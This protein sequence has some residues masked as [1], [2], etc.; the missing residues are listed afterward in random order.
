[1]ELDRRTFLKGVAAVGG[2]AA[3]TGLA[4][5]SPQEGESDPGGSSGSSGSTVEGGTIYTKYPNLDGIGILH[6]TEDEETYDFVIVG[7]GITGLTAA[8]ITAEQMGEA[9]V[10]I[11]DKMPVPGGS[12][13]FAEIQSGGQPTTPEAA[14]QRAFDTAKASSYMKNPD[15]L[16][17]LYLD[18]SK[19]GGWLFYKQGFRH[20]KTN[21]FYEGS[22]AAKWVK[23]L[24]DRI[25]SDSTYENIEIRVDTQV[26]ALLMEDSHTCVGVQAHGTSDVGP[27]TNIKAKAIL[28]ATGGCSTNL[29]LL[30]YYTGHDVTEKGIGIGFGQDGDGFLLVENTAHGQAKDIYPTGMFN[31][32]K[33]FAFSSA[34]GS[35]VSV[36][37]TNCLVNEQGKR[38]INEEEANV[39]AFAVTAKSI[40]LYG[41]VFS[42]MGQNLKEHYQKNGLDTPFWYYY[43]E[44]VD[45]DAELERYKGN[46]YVFTADTLEELAEKIGV[47]K[48]EFVETVQTYDEQATSGSGEP[49][50]G[51]TAV[52]M[53]PLGGGP[54]YAFRLFSGIIQTN[55]GI[56]INVNCEVVDPFFVPIKGLFAGGIAASGFNGEIYTGGTSQGVGSWS[57]SK[58]ARY[59]V[60]NVL[61]GTVKDD[62]FGDEEYHDPPPNL[63]GNEA[64]KPVLGNDFE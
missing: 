25:G 63:A 20:D 57:G 64:A 15:L 52:A 24:T 8:M 51:K 36:Q 40:E 11:L 12:T 61:G 13:N 26:N 2:A 21:L 39:Y 46:E 37:T 7:S 23:M 16:Y 18:G 44:P 35:A 42:I 62:W 19:N 5:C 59:V 60:E 29:D 54:Y 58:V 50:L 49:I 17:S 6:D 31:N 32:V 41:K 45:L 30:S 14:L 27:Y 34:L 33:G 10:L 47:P 43:K 38:F 55:G 22:S 1:M 28:L 4:A 3:L 53:I 48:D 9:K 56:R